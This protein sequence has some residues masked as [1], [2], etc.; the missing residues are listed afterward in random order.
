MKRKSDVL[1]KNKRCKLL[2]VLT[3]SVSYIL[4]EGLIEELTKDFEVYLITSF[5][6]NLKSNCSEKN[7]I[8]YSL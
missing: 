6:P 5:D 1:G 7:I 8:Y 3:S 4:I 2:Y